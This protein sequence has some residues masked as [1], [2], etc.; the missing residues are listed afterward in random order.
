[1]A[2][3]NS[4]QKLRDE[5][6]AYLDE[7]TIATRASLA[8]EEITTRTG[9]D[10]IISNFRMRNGQENVNGTEGHTTPVDT[11]TQGKTSRCC[12]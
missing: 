10:K 7:R 4:L 5:V 12:D 9:V 2:D 8:S 3:P 1:M 6:N 11:T